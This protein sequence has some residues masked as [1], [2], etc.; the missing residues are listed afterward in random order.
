MLESLVGTSLSL[1]TQSRAIRSVS[2]KVQKSFHS[3]SPSSADTVPKGFV[4]GEIPARDTCEVRHPGPYRHLANAWAAAAMR[5]RGGGFKRKRGI[6][7]FETYGN[8]PGEVSDEE[9]VTVV[10]FPAKQGGAVKDHAA[11]IIIQIDMPIIIR[12]SVSEMNPK[13]TLLPPP[14]QAQLRSRFSM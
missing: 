8:R 5:S 10:H 9:R 2:K 7:P 1:F 14:T 11:L 6:P 12:F 4:S 13:G 3:A